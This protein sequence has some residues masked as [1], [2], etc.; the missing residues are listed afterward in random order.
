MGKEKTILCDI[1]GL[2]TLENIK[3]MYTIY[4]YIHAL[5]KY[6]CSTCFHWCRL[7]QM[8]GNMCRSLVLFFCL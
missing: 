3:T 6:S 1:N 2:F 8:Q 5:I 7:P 4:K